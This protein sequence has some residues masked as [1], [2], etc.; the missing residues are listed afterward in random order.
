MLWATQR[1]SVHLHCNRVV[2]NV[3]EEL[4][5][6][7]VSDI[8]EYFDFQVNPPWNIRFRNIW[9]DCWKAHISV[10]ILFFSF[11]Q[12]TS[13]VVP[14]SCSLCSECELRELPWTK[15]HHWEQPATSP[16]PLLCVTLVTWLHWNTCYCGNCTL[17]KMKYWIYNKTKTDPIT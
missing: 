7:A 2:S 3:S 11:P 15:F 16:S 9:R 13:T 12:R 5:L 1:H 10:I 4:K 14:I 17:P 6:A 8:N